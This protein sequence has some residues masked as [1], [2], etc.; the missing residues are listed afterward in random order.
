MK[1][2]AGSGGYGTNRFPGNPNFNYA[3]NGYAGNGAGRGRS[4]TNPAWM[5]QGGGFGSFESRGDGARAS[6]ST[7]P[8]FERNIRNIQPGST[9][10]M[11]AEELESPVTN[12]SSSAQRDYQRE[13]QSRGYC[14]DPA[15]SEIERWIQQYLQDKFTDTQDKRKLITDL[16]AEVPCIFRVLKAMRGKKFF[17]YFMNFMLAVDCEQMDAF[18]HDFFTFL[19]QLLFPVGSTERPLRQSDLTILD[20]LMSDFFKNACVR[21]I[22][23]D[24]NF[25]G[26][27]KFFTELLETMREQRRK[28]SKGKG[29]MKQT[30]SSSSSS[31]TAAAAASPSD[32]PPEMSQKEMQKLLLKIAAKLPST[33]E[34]ETTENRV[35]TR[36]S[37]GKKSAK[38]QKK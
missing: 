7:V 5:N 21:Q 29:K 4:M 31:S 34:T 36:S 38:R 26:G 11:T 23:S 37:S 30:E 28:D 25:L 10:S 8:P 12:V 2:F 14:R 32:S 33:P 17:R 13:S 22:H 6:S 27:S 20:F 35:T 16:F 19:Q 1:R 3:G 15:V 9:S 18:L 24:P